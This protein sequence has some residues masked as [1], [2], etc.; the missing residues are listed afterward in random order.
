MKNLNFSLTLLLFVNVDIF[1]CCCPKK[2]NY[3]GGFSSGLNNYRLNGMG[4]KKKTII[5]TYPDRSGY[6]KLVNNIYESSNNIVKVPYGEDIDDN[7]LNSDFINV[8]EVN[9]K[10]NKISG[11]TNEENMEIEKMPEELEEI[12]NGFSFINTYFE[13]KNL[14]DSIDVDEVNKKDNEIS[15]LTNEEKME[16]E[17]LE[18]LKEMEKL[19]KLK[20]MEELEKLKE[21]CEGF[22]SINTYFE[23][24]ELEVHAID[25]N[26]KKIYDCLQKYKE[27][28]ESISR[29]ADYYQLNKEEA[30]YRVAKNDLDRQKNLIKEKYDEFKDDF[31]DKFINK[32]DPSDVENDLMSKIKKYDEFLKEFEVEKFKKCINII[33]EQIDF[34]KIIRTE[35]CKQLKVIVELCASI[36]AYYNSLKSVEENI[37]VLLNENK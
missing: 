4:R 22:D 1:T 7:K 24:K 35:L 14:S 16:M 21:I 30:K 2:N 5:A 36:Q 17:K 19:E 27:E 31:G 3:L 29:D 25:E 12:K 20:E 9:K 18:E 37:K 23:K 15:E 34:F 10:N 11:L 26:L 33:E 8:D 6:S 32:Y 13:N 28:Y